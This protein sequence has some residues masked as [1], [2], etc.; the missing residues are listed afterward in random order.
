MT[1]KNIFYEES[2]HVPFL[3]RLPG[4]IT[5]GTRVTDP[6]STRDIFPTVLD[7]LGQPP[8][9]GLDSESLRNVID[10]REKRDF[11]VAEWREDRNVP[12]YMI[13]S[14]DWKLLI[15]K[16]PDADSIDAM[17]NQKD[18]PH[19]MDNLLFE[20]MPESNA[21]VAAELKEK[22]IS[23]LEDTNSPAVQGV[24]DRQLPAFASR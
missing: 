6:V 7:Y 2:V 21:Q 24:R 20:G 14:G 8:V 23:W 1:S 9:D 15:S 3:M 13:R 5:A 11:A 18:D 17:N 19:E 12:T 4:A 16:I 22:L 10:G